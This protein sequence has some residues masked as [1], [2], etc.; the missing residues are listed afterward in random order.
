MT[1]VTTHP[2]NILGCGTISDEEVPHVVEEV[3]EIRAG[4]LRRRLGALGLVKRHLGLHLGHV[5]QVMGGR[6]LR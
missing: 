1:N 5:R 2:L 4:A 3:L 6:H